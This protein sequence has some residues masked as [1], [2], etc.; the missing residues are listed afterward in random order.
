MADHVGAGGFLHGYLEAAFLEGRNVLPDATDDQAAVIEAWAAQGLRRA[1][2]ILMGPPVTDFKVCHAG[3]RASWGGHWTEPC[4]DPGRHI[5]G[6][7]GASNPIVLCDGHFQE[8][9]AAGLVADPFIGREEFKR[10]NPG[11]TVPP[12]PDDGRMTGEARTTG[13]DD[14]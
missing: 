11:I 4:P 7:D 3:R 10:R 13:D 14:R 9:N 1:A 8:L 12:G 6:A 2:D 5:L